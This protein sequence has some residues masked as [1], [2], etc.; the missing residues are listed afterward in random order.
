M[1]EYDLLCDREFWVHNINSVGLAGFFF[2]AMIFGYLS[3]RFGRRKIF[4]IGTFLTCITGVATGFLSKYNILYFMI[5][6]FFFL[7]FT[8]GATIVTFV[9]GAEIL[10]PKWRTIGGIAGMEGFQIGYIALSGLGYAI[11]GWFVQF[12]MIFITPGLLFL[13]LLFY[14]ESFRW[15]FSSGQTEMGI[16]SLKNYA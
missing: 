5:G 12:L 2:G 11:K 7:L 9:Y 4:L 13:S 10:H 1:T 16:Q 8:H 3:D 14:P 6:R 15:Y